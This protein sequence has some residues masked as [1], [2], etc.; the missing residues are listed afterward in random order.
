[1]ID[2]SRLRPLIHDLSEYDQHQVENLFLEMIWERS[3]ADFAILDALIRT[4]R[5]IDSTRK[6]DEE[7]NLTIHDLEAHREQA[8]DTYRKAISKYDDN[9]ESMR[10]TNKWE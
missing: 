4:M 9:L 10:T 5:E 3:E 7:F 2:M 1:M 6:A 8:R